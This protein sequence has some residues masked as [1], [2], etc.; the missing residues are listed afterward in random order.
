LTATDHTSTSLAVNRRTELRAMNRQNST[1]FHHC[2]RYGGSRR[3]DHGDETSEAQF[4]G[5]EIHLISIK[6][7]ATRKLFLIKVE[8]TET[9]DGRRGSIETHIIIMEPRNTHEGVH[10]VHVC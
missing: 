10:S 8:V 6:L 7:I 5:G 2:I 3:V 4:G 9:W 1:T